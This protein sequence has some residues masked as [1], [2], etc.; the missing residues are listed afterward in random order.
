MSKHSK[1]VD[2][3]TGDPLGVGYAAMNDEEV[4]ASLNGSGRTEKVAITSNELLAWSVYEG[5]LAR[6]KRGVADGVDDT[7]KS[8]CE[9]CY[10]LIQRDNTTLDLNDQSRIDML[11][12]LVAYGRITAAER[13]G[14]YNKAT[15]QISR[16]KELGLG[17]VRLGDIQT[18]RA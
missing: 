1:I 8:L 5:R 6:I 9:A 17:R 16:A 11:D 4:V 12:A 3:L 15:R 18:A 2:E 13:D 10:L 14:L 7:E